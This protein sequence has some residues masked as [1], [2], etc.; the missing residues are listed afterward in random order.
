MENSDTFGSSTATPTWQY[1]LE[2]MRHPSAA[3]FVKA[4]KSFIVSFLN[5]TPDAERDSTAVQEFLGNMEAA[6]RSH[7]LWVGCSEEEL[8]NAGEGLEKYVLTKL[9]TRVFAAIPEDVE[10]DKQLHQ[11]MALIQ[12]FVRPEN[13][14]IKPTFQNETSW[15]LAQKELQKINMYKG[16]RD[17]LVCILNCCKVINN[18]LIN[19]SIAANEDHPGADEFLPV[20]IYVT[21][22]A[23][24]PQ[25]HSNLL[26]IQRYRRQN[27]LVAESAYYFTNMLSVESFIMNI[28]A[29][30]LSMDEREFKKNMESARLLLYDLSESSDVLSQTDQRVG[31]APKTQ[32]VEPKQPLS[33]KHQ[34]STV[35]G[36][37]SVNSSEKKS[38]NGESDLKD[39]LSL[40]KIPSISD[41][42]N[43][44][45]TMLL[46]EDEVNHVFRD[47]PYL[48]SQAGDLTAS[49]VEDLLN[50]YK[51]LVFKYVCLA[52]GLGVGTPSPPVADT[53]GQK[54]DQIEIVM[55]SENAG[56]G[57]S[58]DEMH[59]ELPNL[60]SDLV[61]ASHFESES[62]ES[63]FSEGNSES[64]LPEEAAV[65]T[66][67]Q[68][69]D[70]NPHT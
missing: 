29:Q 27:R 45:A 52:K 61:E 18:L 67:G 25:L 68:E 36:Q 47:F 35:S 9:F 28:T 69:G 62:S 66:Q 49:D 40:N 22:K 65:Q 63:K 3:D 54:D 64:K 31:H 7:S 4:I 70:Q 26:Y 8:E 2:R 53:Q 41:L 59:K 12:Q 30:A 48:Y 56:E 14:D 38:K 42:E 55:E 15:L 37:F 60:S 51:Q 50:N 21:I 6:F 10:V 1:F 43:K 16:P 20:L 39:Y 11:K 46:K 5:N 19:A 57:T 58:N 24:P 17:K 34:D 23:N 33:W 44:G 13:L 32:V